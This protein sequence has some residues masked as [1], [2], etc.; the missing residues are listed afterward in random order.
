MVAERWRGILI[1]GW[2]GMLGLLLMM[3]LAELFEAGMANDLSPLAKDPGRAG[4]WF[5]AIAAGV[6]VVVQMLARTSDRRGCS[7]AGLRRNRPLRA[8]VRRSPGRPLHG[9]KRRRSSHDPGRLP[10]PAGRVG[11]GGWVSLG[12][13]CRR[14]ARDHGIRATSMTT[15]NASARTPARGHTVRVN[16]LELY[17]EEYGAGRPLV[18]LHG[19]GGCTQNWHPFTAALSERR[20]LIVVD[21]RGHGHSTNPGNTFTHREAANDVLVLLDALGIEQ[22]SAMGLSSGGMALLHMATSQ[23]Q[24]IDAMVLISSTS[25]FPDQARAIMRQASL[26][27]MPPRVQE[28]Y[29]SCA[30]SRRRTDSSTAF[31]V[32]RATRQPRRHEFHRADVVEHH[33]PDADRAR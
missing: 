18:L 31:P 6:N 11:V 25:H 5:I 27:T 33:S 32:Q 29:R 1:Q 7:L 9:G 14:R 17:Y 15:T 4:L 13:G 22:F 23:P 26:A 21:L 8:D 12:A 20:R 30:N 2:S 19:F 24:C 16:D 3:G 28:M 10:P